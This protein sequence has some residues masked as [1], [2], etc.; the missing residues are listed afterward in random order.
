MDVLNKVLARLIRRKGS[1]FS[2]I[3]TDSRTISEGQFYIPLKGGRFNGHDFI[4]EALAKKA[5]GYVYDD[6]AFA[7]PSGYRVAD[8]NEFYFLLAGKYRRALKTEVIAITGSTGK[9]TVKE[10]LRKII[11]DAFGSCAYTKENENNLFGVAKT[12]LALSEKERYLVIELGTNKKGEIKKETKMCDPDIG[13]CLNIGPGHLE[14]FKSL[15][16]VYREKA[17]LVS[18]VLKK[19]G[20]VIIPDDSM[21]E[22]FKNAENVLVNSGSKDFEKISLNFK[23]RRINI[24]VSCKL[25]MFGENITAAVLAALVLGIEPETVQESIASFSLPRLREFKFGKI[26]V[27]DDSYNANPAS[28]KLAL[29]YLDGMKGRKA[30]V[31]GR[32]LELGSAEKRYETEI[33]ERIRNM[34]PVFVVA[35]GPFAASVPGDFIKMDDPRKIAGYISLRAA[36]IDI[37]LLKGSHGTEVYKAAHLLKG[38]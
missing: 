18:Y 5:A 6:E 38:D 1:S 7:G 17:S 32:M 22:E 19:R 9:T 34:S 24:H 30:L 21:F 29:D 13:I 36:D 35:K 4:K 16:G 14:F 3:S 37:L 11:R 28:F 26:T 31:I 8:T 15:K 10:L 2:G 33:F 27:I 25:A 20:T 12:L 23:G